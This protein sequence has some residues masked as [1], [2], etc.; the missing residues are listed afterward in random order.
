MRMHGSHGHHLLRCRFSLQ[1][2]IDRP[3]P[4][5]SCIPS[6][7]PIEHWRFSSVAIY[8]SHS[9]TY[10]TVCSKQWRCRT[11]PGR[12]LDEVFRPIRWRVALNNLEDDRDY[13]N[14]I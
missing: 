7:H 12:T 5:E 6:L 2:R 9:I 8:T 13:Q 4:H 3:Q 1:I 14:C 10:I 11:C